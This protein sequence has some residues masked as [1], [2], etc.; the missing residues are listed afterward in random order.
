MESPRDNNDNDLTRKEQNNPKGVYNM[1][2]VVIADAMPDGTRKVDPSSF[3][4]VRNTLNG[5]V[6]EEYNLQ[7]AICNPHLGGWK[8]LDEAKEDLFRLRKQFPENRYYLFIC[9]WW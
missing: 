1:A 9:S 5:S 6:C 3:S 2:M 4:T 8:P 7:Y